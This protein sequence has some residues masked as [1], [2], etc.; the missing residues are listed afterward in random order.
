[1]RAN[2]DPQP[3]LPAEILRPSMP[4]PRMTCCHRCADVETPAKTRIT[5]G[6]PAPAHSRRKEGSPAAG[7]GVAERCLRASAAPRAGGPKVAVTLYLTE[8]VAQSARGGA[9]F[10]LLTEYDV[11]DQQVRDRGLRPAR[12]LAT[13]L[14]PPPTI[15]GGIDAG[16][17]AM[18]GER[19]LAARRCAEGGRLLELPSRTCTRVLPGG[20]RRPKGV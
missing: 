6:R 14:K 12:G 17:R 15:S 16:R 1:M 7:G 8:P 13:I 20:S 11:K 19:H 5:R 3:D 18:A 9:S 4:R 2:D 10:R